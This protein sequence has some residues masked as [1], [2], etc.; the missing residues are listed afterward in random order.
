MWC[1]PCGG[2]H[3]GAASFGSRSGGQHHLRKK[4]SRNMKIHKTMSNDVGGRVLL[5]PKP[6][7]VAYY[8]LLYPWGTFWWF[9]DLGQQTLFGLDGNLAFYLHFFDAVFL[10]RFDLGKSARRVAPLRILDVIS[11][12]SLAL[13]IFAIINE[14]QH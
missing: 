13:I 14:P 9:L 3:G 1:A 11:R 8:C 6:Y 2:I 5:R 7:V 12:C 4:H 10:I